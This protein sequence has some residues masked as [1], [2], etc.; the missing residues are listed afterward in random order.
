[1]IFLCLTKLLINSSVSFF[2]FKVQCWTFDLPT[3][4]WNRCGAILTIWFTRPCLHQPLGLCMAGGCLFFSVNLPHPSSPHL[5]FIPHSAFPVPPSTP[6]SPSHDL[7]RSPHPPV[8]L[9]PTFSPS[10]LLNFCFSTFRIPNS[11]FHTTLIKTK[12]GLKTIYCFFCV[13]F[14]NLQPPHQSQVS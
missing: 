2:P 11:N 14:F 12:Y 5:L 9:F 10:H 6:P 3:M 8:F 7:S 13:R 1:M 4:P